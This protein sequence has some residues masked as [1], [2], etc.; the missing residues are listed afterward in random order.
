MQEQAYDNYDQEI[1]Y[2][3]PTNIPSRYLSG[4]KHIFTAYGCAL[5][6]RQTEKGHVYSA[7]NLSNGRT[8]ILCR[9]ANALDKSSHSK[10][11]SKIRAL[12]FRGAG[13]YESDRLPGER[14]PK[15]KLMEILDHTFSNILPRYG[16][17]FRANQLGLA[18]HMIDTVSR[19]GISLAES[20]VGT[21]KTL[22]YLTAAVLAKRGRINDF[23]LRGN[24]PGQ[25]YAE[26]AHL[27][28]VIATS[29]IALQKAIIT[30]YIPE[31][32]TILMEHGIIRTPL[33]CAIRKGKEHYLCEKRLRA[34][35]TDANAITQAALE[36]LLSESASCDLAETEGLTP[37]VKRQICVS[38][39]CQPDCRCYHRC[40]YIRYLEYANGPT[41]DFQITN[42]N[43]FL[44]DVL[45]KA[46]GKRPLLPV[47][48]LA[49][50]DEAHKF[51]V[52][53]RQMYGLELSDGEIPQIAE[54]VHTF[55]DGKSAD[56]VNIHRLAKK[57]D[58]QSSRLFKRL[59]ENSL[60][61]EDYDESGHFPAIMDSETSRHLKNIAGI[62]DDLIA[63]LEDSHA[64]TRFR[65]R[66]EQT[67]WALANIRSRAVALRKYE[68][69][70]CWLERPDDGEDGETLL[71]A[72]PKDLDAR[73]YAD[74]WSMGVPF[75]LTSGTLS[76]SGDFTRM[77]ESMGIDKMSPL[78]VR[79]TS[80]PSPFD[81][82]NNTLLYL[83]KAV[84][85]PDQQDKHYLSGVADEVERL[86]RASHGHAAVLF[87]SYGAMGLV[88]SMLRTRD[89]PY[90]L[91]RMGRRDTTALE[92]FKQS[93]NGIL[94]ASGALWE[95]VDVPG[96]SLSMLIIVKLSFAV[97][98]PIGDYERS[99]FGTMEAYKSRALIPDML[100][101]LK[102]GFGRLIR[103]ESDTG[104]CAILDCRANAS[105]SYHRQVLNA[106]PPCQV[107]SNILE[108]ERFIQ[109][110]KPPSYF[111]EVPIC[112]VA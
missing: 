40:R 17:V 42:H 45:H 13:V 67:A 2:T 92:Q 9:R 94:L 100:M 61:S 74:V 26:G 12:P 64:Q 27:A 22:A 7:V 69:L 102:Q 6:E 35:Y 73:L 93:G 50:I 78:F 11:A 71:R 23:W 19:R 99:L 84:P 16:Y 31:L 89:L 4:G 80:L 90:P 81:Y 28:V 10:M 108:I 60:S 58:G 83:S 57:M 5:L 91:F 96:D 44:A 59:R 110:T 39:R 72:I 37:F 107:T 63:A 86:I 88:Y 43:Y 3:L 85:F 49:I 79:E 97:P 76:A 68:N 101:K 34:F 54:A 77:K 70:I 41:V 53:A 47:Y 103:T 24:L 65:E 29:S 104:V 95:G 56:G 51:L 25:S 30:D 112:K 55:T 48:Q 111:T 14:L 33:T 98:D 105:G 52:A 18:E 62:A 21:G 20:A 1:S 36:P 46:T 8:E 75:I 106:L 109:E 82:K 87:T 32:S 66:K 38:G 15:D